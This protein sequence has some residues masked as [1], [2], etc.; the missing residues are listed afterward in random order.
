MAIYTT[1]SQMQKIKLINGSKKARFK[2]INVTET[3]MDFIRTLRRER[4]QGI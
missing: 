3:T 1:T 2:Y 4:R